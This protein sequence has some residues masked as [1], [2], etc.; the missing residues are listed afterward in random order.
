MDLSALEQTLIG[1]IIAG[2]GSCLGYVVGMRGRMT[3]AECQKC[4]ATCAERMQTKLDAVSA[5]YAELSL[6]QDR[7]DASLDT[8]LDILFRMVRAIVMH[9]PIDADEKAKIVNERSGK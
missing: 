6:H 8:K 5:K 1:V 4:Q 2:G 3:L 9:L 7:I